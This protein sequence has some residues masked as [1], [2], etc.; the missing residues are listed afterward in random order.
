MNDFSGTKF[1]N[2]SSVPFNYETATTTAAVKQGSE[3]DGIGPDQVCVSAMAEL[4][5]VNT[6]MKSTDEFSFGM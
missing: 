5:I 6:G 2:Q 1:D 3:C 4:D